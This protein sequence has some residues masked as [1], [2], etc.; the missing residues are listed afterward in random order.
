MAFENVRP[1]YRL[2]RISPLAYPVAIDFDDVHSTRYSLSQGKGCV[3]REG[4]EEAAVPHR[5]SGFAV[6]ELLGKQTHGP[7]RDASVVRPAH[8]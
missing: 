5:V 8:L 2:A 4:L 7:W 1:G 6:E 3:E